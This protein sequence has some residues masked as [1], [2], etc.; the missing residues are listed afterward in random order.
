MKAMMAI[1]AGCVILGLGFLLFNRSPG[2]KI[3]PAEGVASETP[4]PAL[5]TGMG[6]SSPASWGSPARK[7]P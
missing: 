4:A 5:P 3:P 6:C 2:G 7:S 1:S